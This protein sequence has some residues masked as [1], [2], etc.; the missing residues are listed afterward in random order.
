MWNSPPG[1]ERVRYKRCGD[2][3]V[4]VVV[5][6]RGADAVAG[7]EPVVAL[8]DWLGREVCPRS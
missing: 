3:R 1:V 4:Q 2:Q 8:G 6:P 5:Q 7:D